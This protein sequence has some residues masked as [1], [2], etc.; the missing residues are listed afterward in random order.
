[1]KLILKD[2]KLLCRYISTIL[3][4]SLLCDVAGAVTT[5]KDK[6]KDKKVTADMFFSA[7]AI[8]SPILSPNGEYLSY[9]NGDDIFISNGKTEHK[10][11]DLDVTLDLLNYQWSS[12]QSIIMKYYNNTDGYVYFK[13]FHFASFKNKNKILSIKKIN[14]NGYV[15]D[16]LIDDPNHIIFGSYYHEDDRYFSKVFKINTTKRISSQF[17]S[18]LRLE[19]W[20]KK[21]KS[22]LTDSQ[23]HLALGLSYEK[24]LATIWRKRAKRRGWEIKWQ[25]KTKGSFNPIKISK[26][27]TKFWAITNIQTDRK[28]AIEFDLTHYKINHTIYKEM[29]T[30]AHG[31]VFDDNGEPLSISFLKK[32]RIH[33][34][35]ISSQSGKPLLL[36]KPLASH[37]KIFQDINYKTHSL[38]L[39]SFS[40]T[41]P[42]AVYFCKGQPYDCHKIKDYY[43]ELQNVKLG[44]TYAH[45]IVSK[46]KEQRF[47]LEFFVTLPAK[48]SAGIKSVPLIVMPHGGPIGVSDSRY[49]NSEVQW[50]A[51]HGYAVLQVNYRGSIGYGEKFENAG[52][53][54]WGRGIEDDID[55]AINFSLKTYPQLDPQRLAIFGS[56]YGGYSALMSIIR[57]H[58]DY[59]CAIAFAG[60]TD[61]TLL[62]AKTSVKNSSD[63]LKALQKIVGDPKKQRNELI[64]YSPVYQYKKINRPIFLIHGTKDTTVDIEHSYRMDALLDLTPIEHKL[65]ILDGIGHGFRWVKDE[66]KFYDEVLKF[67]DKHL[68]K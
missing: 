22:W 41:N 30:D 46:S 43:P 25:S 13:S 64:Q 23:H 53:G 20:N 2:W 57:S 56:S 66:I 60:V 37:D 5:S 17:R 52:L 33:Y 18:K 11:I 39:S 51:Y 16:P 40:S 65:L 12:D 29:P 21:I 63:T 61:L 26:D 62:F 68:K 59:K 35:N 14:K 42:G 38:V 7:P 31:I 34:E 4:F 44:H 8:H 54:E 50:L 28:V 67:L 36:P 48:S 47:N 24:G 1:M 32:G 3:V 27:G 10:V 19:R 15:I 9:A 45:S 58:I 49:F 55:N 6:V